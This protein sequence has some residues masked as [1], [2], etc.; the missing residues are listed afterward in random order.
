MA[1]YWNA[2]GSKNLAVFCGA[3]ISKNSGI[4]LADELKAYV[5]SLMPICTE[6]SEIDLIMSALPFEAFMEIV[7]SAF[8]ITAILDVFKSDLTFSG[9]PD[10]SLQVAQ[11]SAVQALCL[12]TYDYEP[13]GPLRERGNYGWFYDD[14]GYYH[15]YR[16]D[17]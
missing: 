7:Q 2:L 5:L 1:N 17:D 11:Q 9:V 16:L 6:K 3:G 10:Y 13:E 8:P 4:P 15:I 12:A 14:E